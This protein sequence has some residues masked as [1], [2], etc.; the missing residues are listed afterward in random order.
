MKLWLKQTLVTLAV[1]LLSVSM[2]LYHFVA[3]ETDQLIQQAI[4]SGARDTAVFCDHLSTLERTSTA[5]DMD[6]ITRQAL[7]QYTFSTYAHLL[8]TGDCTWSLVMD[9]Q[10]CY[11]TA[12]CQPMETLP[13]AEDAVAA[14]RIVERGGTHLLISAQ[15]MSV[16]QTPLTVYRAANIKSTYQHIN[17]LTRAAQLSLLG[18]LLLCGVLLPLMLRKTLAPLR[19]LAQISDKIACGAYELRV[20][21]SADDEVGELARAFD[22]MADTVEQKIADLEDTARRR[23]LLLGALTHEMKTP[24]TAIIGFSG[25][26]LS[27]PLTEEGRMEAAYEIHE[28]AKRTERLSQ[29]MM[30]LISLQAGNAAVQQRQ[31]DARELLER[32]CAAMPKDAAFELAVH[33]E[34]LTGDPDLLFCFLTNVVDNA[35]KASPAHA[36]IRLSA[37]KEGRRQVLAVADAGGGIPA[38]K[39]PLVTEPFYRVDKARSRKLGGAGLGLSLCRMIAEAHGGQLE[40]Q[41]EVGKGTTV[42]MIW[43]TEEKKSA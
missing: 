11:N 10:Y 2:C 16:L 36:V 23:E 33:T 28:A 24:M 12:S 8:Q 32:V 19:K 9:G 17:D 34:T 29:K 3:Q 43:C 38:D 4:Q 6:I 7:I 42:S 37:S 41:S 21:I 1:I 5:Y 31:V 40:I 25:S 26:L 39:I 30:Q 14:S 22:H 18:C 35:I 20:N 13:M 27:M 15:T